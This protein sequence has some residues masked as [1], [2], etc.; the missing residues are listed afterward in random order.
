MPDERILHEDD[1]K[2][3]IGDEI[4]TAD[5]AE[6][7]EDDLAYATKTELSVASPTAPGVTYDQAEAAS[8][9][10]AVDAIIAALVENGTLVLAE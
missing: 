6:D 5:V 9:K 2:E 1:V 7:A 3:V 4:D 8:M 10:T